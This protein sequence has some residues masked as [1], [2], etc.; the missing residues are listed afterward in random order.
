M[1]S[2]APVVK[3]PNTPK[4]SDLDAATERKVPKK[5]KYLSPAELAELV[6]PLKGRAGRK[7]K[8][9]SE[10]TIREWCK[11][12]RIP[13]AYRTGGGHWRIRI[14][15][16][17]KTV[18]ELEKR[19][20]DWPFEKGAGDLQGDFTTE[21]V[22]W[23]MLAELYQCRLDEHLPIP[24]IAELGDPLWEGIEQSTDPKA[25]KAR[26]I[27]D[28]IMRRVQNKEPVSDLLPTGWVY[29]FW[30]SNQRLPTVEDVA[31]LMTLSRPALYRRGYNAKNR[32]EDYL[33][34]TAERKRDL[35]AP[36]GLDPVQRQ[37]LKAKK[38]T[39]RDP[40]AKN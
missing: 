33:T 27:Q 30:L 4:T 36:D 39:Y 6:G 31:E 23:L 11:Q 34:A 15:L 16:S 20:A 1:L 2:I 18:L 7:R 37:N 40:F 26:K 12:G 38:R 9:C 25:K 17:A 14:P 32:D 21:F 13:E 24:T 28:E 10:R 8:N 5:P 29:Q 35:P 19:R 3:C 22:E